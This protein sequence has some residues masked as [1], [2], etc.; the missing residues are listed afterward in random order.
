VE[1]EWFVLLSFFFFEASLAP[2]PRMFTQPNMA[3][4]G[5][6]GRGDPSPASPRAVRPDPAPPWLALK[7][8]ARAGLRHGRTALALAAAALGPAA[9][10]SHMAA[11][12]PSP[13]R[14][15]QVRPLPRSAACW[16]KKEMF[17]ILAPIYV[18]KITN[19]SIS[20]LELYQMVWWKLSSTVELFHGGALALER[21]F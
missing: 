15:A 17:F 14:A 21:C 6:T 8:R 20:E 18:S 3:A 19:E 11:A 7:R 1:N 2:S 13:G 10:A 9:P 16:R 4:A 5:R 12:S